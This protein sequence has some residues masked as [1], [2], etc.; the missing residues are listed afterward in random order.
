M[1]EGRAAEP[2]VGGRSHAKPTANRWARNI[3]IDMS[4]A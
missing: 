3:P 1:N 4:L 2:I